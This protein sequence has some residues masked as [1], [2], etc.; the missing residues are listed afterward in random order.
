MDSL[1]V[2]KE[3]DKSAKRLACLFLSFVLIVLFPNLRGGPLLVGSQ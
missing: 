3:C 1:S 2:R